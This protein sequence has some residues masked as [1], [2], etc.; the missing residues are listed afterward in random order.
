MSFN[1]YKNYF[2]IFFITL[3]IVFATKLIFYWYLK[4]NF[5]SI[6]FNQALYA[7]IWGYKFDL[8]AAASIAFFVNLFDLNKLL[9]RLIS[10]SLIISVLFLQISDIFYFYESSRHIGYE[11]TDAYQDAWSL[12]LTAYSQHSLLTNLTIITAIILFVFYLY[13]SKDFKAEKFNRYY[14]L[15]KLVVIFVSVFFIR[16]LT[17]SIPLNP[18][19]ANQIGHNVL[20]S[21]SL[22]ATYNV[23]YT[24]TNQGKKL[25]K[26]TIPEVSK[27]KAQSL[28]E[29]LYPTQISQDDNQNYPIIKSKPNVVFLFLESWSATY[30]KP[31]GAIHDSTPNFNKILSNAMRTDIMLAGGHRTTEGIFSTL[32]SFQNPLGKTIAK[33]QLE[34]FKYHSIINELNNIGYGSAFF[35]GTSKETSGTGSFVQNLG[36]N[37]SYGKRDIKNRI[38]N[39]NFWGVQ[40]TDLYNYVENKLTSTIKEPFVI[41]ING[42]TTHDTIIPDEIREIKF[43]DDQQL[44]KMLNAFHFADTALIN[45]VNKTLQRF[46]NTVFVLLADH[47]GKGI[48]GNFEN[49]AIPFAIYSPQLIEAKFYNQISSQRDVAPTVYDLI[50][51]NYK[52]SQL[53]FTGKSLFRNEKFF[54]DYYHNGVLGWIEDNKI[55]EINLANNNVECYIHHDHLKKEVTLC[56]EEYNALK[57]NALAFTSYSQSLIFSGKTTE[58]F[59]FQKK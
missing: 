41:G 6:S 48:S 18:W 37:L 45:F 30:L 59:Q 11:I 9:Y 3:T 33:T 39:E 20:S 16:G 15:N 46:P 49:Y 52:N 56:T 21:L 44:N 5:T 22:N 28:L 38:Y 12:F 34:S 50:I 4:P 1:T 13:L 24:L 31:Y 35:Q 42:A 14:L 23:I 54:S 19:Q 32:A 43:A 47:C 26:L 10:A 8:A 17:Q 36:F 53:A 25:N 51:G 55:I 2:T 57:D 40:D 7:I 27:Q 58:F 29:N